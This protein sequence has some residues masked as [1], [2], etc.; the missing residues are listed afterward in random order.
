MSLLIGRIE[1]ENPETWPEP[2][3]DQ[4]TRVGGVPVPGARAGISVSPT[5]TLAPDDS[6]AKA[7]RQRVRRQVRSLMNNPLARLQG[8]WVKWDQ[9]DEQSGWFVPS[10]GTV[11]M[12][13]GAL[14]GGYFRVGGL[15]LELVGRPRTHRRALVARIRDLRDAD[16][17]K[18]TMKRLYGVC[19][20][21]SGSVGSNVTPAAQVWLPS[22]VG[23]VVA[24]SSDTPS[25]GTARTGRD[26]T[27]V[28]PVTGLSDLAV[29]SMEQ[30]P[31][32]RGRG[33]VI[34]YDRRAEAATAPTDG[35]ADDWEEV[36]GP[37]WPW[38]GDLVIDNYLCR[39][40]CDEQ[41][42]TWERWDGS[43]YTSIGT[44]E[45]W[46]SDGTAGQLDSVSSTSIHEWTPERAV[47][48]RVWHD[49]SATGS[50]CEVF[51]TVQR[52]WL[53]PRVEAY[54]GSGWTPSV[55]IFPTGG[56]SSNNV[57]STFTSSVNSGSI[58]SPTNGLL[59]AVVQHAATSGAVTGGVEVV[60][61]S[62]YV[63]VHLSRSATGDVSSA[64][65]VLGA[66]VLAGTAYPQAIVPR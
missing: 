36:Y 66:D 41:E 34:V 44:L 59:V 8:V 55:R 17:P 13:P 61:A 42:L 46:N 48:R 26:T 19:F 27:S 45:V 32:D 31:P 47:V 62:Q 2:L 18:D 30:E 39:L 6:G 43:A 21:G 7:D 51:V 50:R 16:E 65:P 5:V 14:Q 57:P 35:P 15:S 20:D 1:L 54:A 64:H 25:L 29:V 49:D 38:V 10:S 4:V 24:H 23:D 3:G 9:D 28:T 56:V 22:T 52:G 63:S 53:G 60:G 37:D 58:V 11:D 12:P 33:D 40:V